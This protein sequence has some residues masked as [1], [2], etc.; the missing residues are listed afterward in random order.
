MISTVLHNATIIDGTGRAPFITDV[1]IAGDRIA[2]IGSLEERD[3]ISH[4]DCSGLTLAPG[5][6][7]V[8]SHSDELWLALP[9]CDG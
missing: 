1:G 4:I 6:I 8:H 5:F 9:R 7:D 3:A 2:L